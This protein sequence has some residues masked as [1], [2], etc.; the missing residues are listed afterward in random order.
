MQLLMKFEIL[1]CA[2]LSWSLLVFCVIS[3][4]VVMT[5]GLAYWYRSWWTIVLKFDHFCNV[6]ISFLKISRWRLSKIYID[7]IKA[8]LW[9][10]CAKSK[11]SFY[12]L[13]IVF[14]TWITVYNNSDWV[15]ATPWKWILKVDYRPYPPLIVRIETWKNPQSL[16]KAFL[17]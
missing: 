10:Y 2:F 13:F 5:F 6:F 8:D 1:H 15:S 3:I 11:N 7:L 4:I 9:Q 12:V 16:L 14:L 17:R